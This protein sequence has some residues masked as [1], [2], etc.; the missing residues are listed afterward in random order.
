MKDGYS[1]LISP[2][3][4]SYLD[5]IAEDELLHDE[6]LEEQEEYELYS[7]TDDEDFTEDYDDEN[8]DDSALYS[9]AS[10]FIDDDEQESNL[11]R[12]LKQI[13]DYLPQSS[14]TSYFR[15]CDI[16][17]Q[18][19]VEKA[20]ERA[21]LAWKSD[22]KDKMFVV[23]GTCITVAVV[24]AG[25]GYSAELKR[26]Q[27][28]ASVMLEHNETVWTA[29]FAELDSNGEMCGAEV[30]KVQESLFTPAQWQAVRNLCREKRG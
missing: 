8:P 1:G 26:L 17:Q 25:K 12:L 3:A 6:L 16:H 5:E 22:G 20:L 10:L 13:A 4:Y 28:I 29:L 21:C 2:D 14:C 18:E 27:S 9:A 30:R 15:E 7:L 24:G 23:P 19:R 11:P